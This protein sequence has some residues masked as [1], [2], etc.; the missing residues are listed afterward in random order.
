MEKI[1]LTD[2]SKALLKGGLIVN[3]AV[4]IYAAGIGS[5][6]NN[7][8]G[9]K[10]KCVIDING[11]SPIRHTIK[12]FY[13]A[14]I[15]D[16]IIVVGFCCE[17]VIAYIQKLI[18]KE[19]IDVRIKFAINEKYDFHGCEYSL[20]CGFEQSEE[21]N[22]VYVLEGDMLLDYDY[23]D[24][25]V[26]QNCDDNAVLIGKTEK[27]IESKSV[28]ACGKTTEKVNYFAYDDGHRMVSNYVPSDMQVLGESLQLWKFSKDC[29]IQLKKDYY[30]YFRLAAV[31]STKMKENGLVYINKA[32]NDYGLTPIFVDGKKAIN[33]NTPEDVEIARKSAWII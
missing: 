8:N 5:R 11:S 24:Q 20:S 3:K 6:M 23:I 28:V 30:E 12:C 32:A 19:N 25:M 2:V 10:S 1:G 26:N 7:D 16:F 4:I 29:L 17:T 21:Y 33:L 15:R 13:K 18:E 14:G 27:I 31:S 22:V 9:K